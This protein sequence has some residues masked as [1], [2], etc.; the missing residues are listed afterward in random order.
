MYVVIDTETT[1]G[2]SEKDR[3]IEFAA[4]GLRPDGSEEWEWCSLINPERDTGSGLVRQVHQIFP[5]D[6]ES[7]PVFGDIA[8]EIAGMMDGRAVIAHNARFD[9][10]MLGSEFSRLGIRLPHLPQICTATM[11]REAGFRPYSLEACCNAMCIDMDGMHHALA[12]ARSTARLVRCLL[13]FSDSSLR[14]SV[15]SHLRSVNRWPSLETR[16]VKPLARRIL[17]ARKPTAN[18]NSRKGTAEKAA[19]RISSDQSPPVV[20]TFSFDE[21][22]SESRY[23]AVVEQVL[24]DREVP[25]EQS[26]MLDSLRKELG[27]SSPRVQDIH[28]TFLRGLAGS[29]W[30]DGVI[31]DHEQFDLDLVGELLRLSAKDVE[32]ARDNPI[33]LGL[34]NQDYR[35]EAGDRIVF[36]GEMSVPRSELKKYAE[37]LGLRVTGSVS[38]LT[39]YLVVPFGKTGSGKSLKARKLGIRVISEQRF[40]RMARAVSSGE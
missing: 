21:Q 10:G 37:D 34:V 20:E 16:G 24:E 1:G 2:N 39:N 14:E 5:K 29:M 11:A 4:V 7:A 15:E 13:D 32:Y 30:E 25:E 18:L 31:D 38:K 19:N 9:L 26:R 27:L 40:L 36:T 22:S 33:G 8:A 6:V 3:I 12:D 28:L 17:P 23:L 35:L